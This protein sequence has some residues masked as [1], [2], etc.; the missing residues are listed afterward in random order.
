MDVRADECERQL[1]V[2]EKERDQWEGKYE[3]RSSV[4]FRSLLPPSSQTLS[5]L[6]PPSACIRNSNSCIPPH[7]GHRGKVPH[8]QG[9]ARRARLPDGGALG[10]ALGSHPM[11]PIPIRGCHRLADVSLR[12]L[13][14]YIFAVFSSCIYI[15]RFLFILEWEHPLESCCALFLETWW[16]IDVVASGRAPRSSPNVLF[17]S[18]DR[19]RFWSAS[20]HRCALVLNLGAR[21]ALLCCSCPLRS[22]SADHATSCSL[23]T[24]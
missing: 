20:K 19:A 16:L 7:P 14:T 11:P 23:M 3:V 6:S 24:E 13:Y 2:A 4:F 17:L 8:R 18:A 1:K 15:F 21:C 22:L 5:L 12:I 10:A 9:R